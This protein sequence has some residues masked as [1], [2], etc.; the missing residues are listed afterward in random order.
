MEI[1]ALQELLERQDPAT[2]YS[3]D[4]YARYFT[5]SKG[6]ETH[7]I[8]YDDAETLRQKLRL[9]REMGLCAAFLMYPEIKDLLPALFGRRQSGQDP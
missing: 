7:F 4:L 8:L 5:F 1:G 6:D 9:G 3:R 2:F